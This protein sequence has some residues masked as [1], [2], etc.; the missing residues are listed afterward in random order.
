MSKNAFKPQTPEVINARNLKFNQFQGCI[1]W[2]ILTLSFEIYSH[3]TAYRKKYF[4]RKSLLLT[5]SAKNFDRF[6]YTAILSCRFSIQIFKGHLFCKQCLHDLQ[7]KKTS[8]NLSKLARADI[9]CQ[10]KKTRYLSRQCLQNEW[11]LAQ[12]AKQK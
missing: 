4:L 8:T 2:I 10:F 5:I 6:F 9:S 3:K 7:F 11:T 12:M 1:F